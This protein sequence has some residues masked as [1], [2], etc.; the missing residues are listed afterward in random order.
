V[1]S[2]L[3]IQRLYEI[4]D[5]KKRRPIP[6][7]PPSTSTLASKEDFYTQNQLT[8][9]VNIRPGIFR[10]GVLKFAM[11]GINGLATVTFNQGHLG[12]IPT[13]HFARWVILDDRRLIFFSNFDGTW[14]N[15]LGDFIDKAN[16]GLTLAWSS[17][18]DFPK[19][20]L[21]VAQ[22]ARDG[23]RFKRWTRFHQIPTQVWYT[24][25][26]EYNVRNITNALRLCAG[27][28]ASSLG[29]SDAA[30]WLQRV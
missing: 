24:A 12:R 4:S 13:I 19:S 8:H 11:W 1:G 27:L 7:A 23:E 25:L 30:A 15:Y 2:A 26:P 22:G 21:I 5:D 17:T 20:Y 16:I 18:E 28:R 14:D 9:I 10:L 3:A 6:P 29:E